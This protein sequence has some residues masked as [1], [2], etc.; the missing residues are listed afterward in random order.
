MNCPAIPPTRPEEADALP[1]A[2]EDHQ[3]ELGPAAGRDGASSHR[4][5]TR[6]LRGAV[7]PSTRSG[8]ELLSC[9]TTR[10]R[11]RSGA[12]THRPAR[13][14]RT[15]AQQSTTAARQSPVEVPA[16]WS[17]SDHRASTSPGG[18]IH[19]HGGLVGYLEHVG[20]TMPDQFGKD[21]YVLF[22]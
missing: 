18:E 3:V 5:G 10:P 20:T 17:P 13:A 7:H 14:R 22:Q 12:S 11:S 21:V 16:V 4:G 15:C 19:G 8:T 6:R 9:S 2:P 1:A